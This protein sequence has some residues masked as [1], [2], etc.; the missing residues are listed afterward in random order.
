MTRILTLDAATCTGWCVTEDGR[1]IASGIFQ[2][3]AKLPKQKTGDKFIR[4]P[5]IYAEA[6]VAYS[7]V[8]DTYEVDWIVV[9]DPHLRGEASLLTVSLHAVAQLVAHRRQAGF[10]S[11]RTSEWQSRI[12]PK[13]KGADPDTKKRSEAHVK[14]QGF[15]PATHDEADAICVAEY[16]HDHLEL[17]EGKFPWAHGRAA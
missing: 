2:L 5:A 14:A 12:I 9:E 3:D 8:A 16:V 7:T 11:V 4:R 13:T 17:T 15:D 10:Y 1:V 6:Y